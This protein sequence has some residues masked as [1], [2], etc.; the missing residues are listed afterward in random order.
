M[1]TSQQHQNLD[2]SRENRREAENNRRTARLRMVSVALGGRQMKES[3]Q[4]AKSD[5]DVK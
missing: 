4:T 2:E 1:P 3:R 5:E